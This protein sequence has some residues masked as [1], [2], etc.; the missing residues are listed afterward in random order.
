MARRDHLKCKP[1][2]QRTDRRPT[3][4]PMTEELEKVRKVTEMAVCVCK[5]FG[6]EPESIRSELMEGLEDSFRY[7]DPS[8][9]IKTFSLLAPGGVEPTECAQPRDFY[10]LVLAHYGFGTRPGALPDVYRQEN[11]MAVVRRTLD[12]LLGE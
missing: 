4:A 11:Y 3:L 6:K 8:E 2:S 1:P 9:W 5:H 7:K 10:R 12:E